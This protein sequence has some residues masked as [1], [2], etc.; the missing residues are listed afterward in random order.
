MFSGCE[1]LQDISELA[2]W[3][4]SN[5]KNMSYMFSECK[6]LQNITALANWD[7]SSVENMSGMFQCCER[8]QY[9]NAL[10]NWDMSNVK[11]TH[12]MFTVCR[13]LKDISALA[14]WDVSNVKN[15]SNMFQCCERLQ[16]I[17][18]LANWDVSKVENMNGMFYGCQGLGI[19]DN[20]DIIK[21]R[22]RNIHKRSYPKQD[23]TSLLQSLWERIKPLLKYTTPLNNHFKGYSFEDSIKA[24][25]KEN[26]EL[27]AIIQQQQQ[28]IEQLQKK[29]ANPISLLWNP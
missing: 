10:A 18:A 14:N 29:I 25:Q 15:M 12:Y 4:V 3:D 6:Q 7:V 17:N 1:Q 24:L 27:K 8:L 23:H 19:P 26:A 20:T 11:Y 21:S 28:T 22:L 5:V 13:Q 9:I 2:N 16:Y